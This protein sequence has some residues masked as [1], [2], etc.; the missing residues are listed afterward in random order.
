MK[1]LSPFRRQAMSQTA[2]LPIFFLVLAASV[3]AGVL[4]QA[5]AP[6]QEPSKS[7]QAAPQESTVPLSP[8]EEAE[9]KGTAVRMS[10]KDL[11]KLA[12]Q[13]NLDIAIS[14]TNEELFRQRVIGSYG[15]YDPA[16]NIGFG[17]LNAK[18]PNT[19][20]SLIHI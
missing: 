17:V 8:T 9:K 5:Q 6:A 19:R 11:T 14:D 3:P 7:A 20:L 15:Q 10:L 13:N 16:L 12:L 4:A 2:A 1:S 18:S